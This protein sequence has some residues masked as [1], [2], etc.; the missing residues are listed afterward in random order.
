V[1][2]RVGRQQM[3]AESGEAAENP[4]RHGAALRRTKTTENAIVSKKHVFLSYCHEDEEEVAL[5]RQ[6]FIA[7][8]VAV[9]WDQDILPGEDRQFEIRQAMKNAC[10][11]VICLSEKAAKRQISAIFA[12]TRDGIGIYRRRR[13]DSIFLILTRLSKCDIP[14]IEIDDSRTLDRL[15]YVDL[16][17]EDHRKEN[18]ERLIKAVRK[19]SPP[20][21]PLT[22]SS[23]DSTPDAASQPTAAPLGDDALRTSPAKARVVLSYGPQAK[24]VLR[25]V[26]ALRDALGNDEKID[27]DPSSR[28]LDDKNWNRQI[29]SWMDG[30]HAAIIFL[31]QNDLATWHETRTAVLSYRC[32]QQH[33]FLLL[34][35]LVDT[36]FEDLPHETVPAFAKTCLLTS[37]ESPEKAVDTVLE[38]LGEFCCPEPPRWPWT[39]HEKLVAKGAQHLRDAGFTEKELVASVAKIE[40]FPSISHGHPN[41][42]HRHLVE[43]L[44]RID[45]DVACD[46][47]PVL[48]KIRPPAREDLLALL[49]VMFP[50]WV[51]NAKARRIAEM[52]LNDQNR[53]QLILDV[54]EPDSVDAVICRALVQSYQQ[55][56]PVYRLLPPEHEDYSSLRRQILEEV[57]PRRP[58]RR[59]E[60]NEGFRLDRIRRR[61][62]KGEPVFL[63]FPRGWSPDADLLREIRNELPNPTVITMTSPNQATP[64]EFPFSDV[65]PGLEREEIAWS[66]Y[67]DT[68]EGIEE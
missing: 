45:F 41:D 27:L 56:V 29:Y 54:E 62:R 50:F 30:A 25:Y 4:K 5:L 59:A 31:G 17:P 13:P 23:Y 48:A 57:K 46:V 35:I 6:D 49:E 52:V 64:D 47:L 40:E 2:H 67:G 16:F 19:A 26:E 65:S 42:C 44:L 20:S 39:P 3:G 63:L 66:A 7:A 58:S 60:R 37:A 14:S 21:G 55:R 8:D 9:W 61:E 22:G 68:R 15:Q 18:L 53:R 33:R 10:A 28:P 51:P 36:V 38:R 12:E 32:C 24:N 1:K 43:H 34:P 11:V